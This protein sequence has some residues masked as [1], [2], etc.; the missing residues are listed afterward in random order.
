MNDSTEVN[1]SLVEDLS[2]ADIP[3]DGVRLATELLGDIKRHVVMPT[4]ADYTA[5]L[6]W[7]FGT[8]FMDTWR[9]WPKLLVT[10]PEKRCGKSTLL[11]VLEGLVFKALLTSSVTASALFRVISDCQPTLLIDEADRFIKQNDE[12]NGIINAG[13]T[14]RTAKV[15][16]TEGRPG[17]FTPKYFSVWTSQVFASIGKQMD[18]LHDRSIHIKLRRRLPHEHREK[19]PSDF[20]ERHFDT[21]ARIL[22]WANDH[23]EQIDAVNIEPPECGN[24]RAQD[25]WGPLFQ[26]ADVIG[27]AWPDRAMKAYVSMTSNDMVEDET[28]GAMLLA[29]LRSILKERRIERVST[30]DLV[31]M[32]I[33]LEDR[34]WKE[35]RRGRPLTSVTI[36]RLLEPY[37]IKPK[38]MKLGG[39]KVRGYSATDFQ[40]AFNRYGSSQDVSQIGTPVPGNE[41]VAFT[42]TTAGTSN[43]GVPPVNRL[44]G[45]EDAAG[46][47]VLT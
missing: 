20:F 46:T 36:S 33:G 28:A 10:S 19:M 4:D 30:A 7:V 31:D 13:H 40:D 41:N 16:K 24:D 44:I 23:R 26:I 37:Q 3:V 39:R 27:G 47:G 32:L 18:T 21:R 38:Q 15:L 42:E 22:R 35:W 29:D 1:G 34:P 5:T 11:E 8:Y 6:L 9:L 25:N 17:N 43:G 14:R 45:S 2:P 12:L